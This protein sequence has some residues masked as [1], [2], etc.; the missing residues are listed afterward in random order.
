MEELRLSKNTAD[1]NECRE[2]FTQSKNSVVSMY[3][4]KISDRIK[5]MQTRIY[6]G[7]SSE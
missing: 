2:K 4:G 1:Q 7:E 3:V 5:I 6:A